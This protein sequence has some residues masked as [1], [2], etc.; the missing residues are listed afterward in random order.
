MYT[1]VNVNYGGETY[2]VK[3]KSNLDT[4]TA[5]WRK[6]L[7]SHSGSFNSALSQSLYSTEEDVVYSLCPLTTV[8]IAVFM[9]QNFTD[10]SLVG[11]ML[12]INDV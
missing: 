11:S 5:V 6:L 3:Q 8:N 10:G 7:K 12:K 2:V 4:M 1:T 9:K